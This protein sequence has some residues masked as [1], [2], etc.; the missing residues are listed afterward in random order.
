MHYWLEQS[1]FLS[2]HRAQV[3]VV[4]DME[5]MQCISVLVFVSILLHN[6]EHNININLKVTQTL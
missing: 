3:D 2:C 1:C 6:A 5:I 4:E